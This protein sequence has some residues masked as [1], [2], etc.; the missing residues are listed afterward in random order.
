MN[1]S[2]LAASRSNPSSSDSALSSTIDINS[3]SSNQILPG[4][5]VVYNDQ[6][7]IKFGSLQREIQTFRDVCE[8]Y[9]HDNILRTHLIASTQIFLRKTKIDINTEDLQKCSSLLFHSIQILSKEF[10]GQ[11]VYQNIRA[12]DEKGW[13]SSPPRNDWVWVNIVPQNA[14]LNELPYKALRG[15]LPYR[16]LRTFKLVINT[17]HLY[18]A[19]VEVTKPVA[20]GIPNS[21]SSMVRVVPPSGDNPVNFKIIMASNICGAA[22]LTP[23]VPISSPEI[24]TG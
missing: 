9:Q 3:S 8:L 19:F 1:L 6:R 18:L 11:L 15:R 5:P 21:I 7:P 14:H 17:Q 16:L 2:S 4:I 10:D 22:H 12:T 24:N 13:Y 23:E 20:G